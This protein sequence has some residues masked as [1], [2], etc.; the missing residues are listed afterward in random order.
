MRPGIDPGAAR[1][2]ATLANRALPASRYVSACY[3]DHT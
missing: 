1:A 2:P 3:D